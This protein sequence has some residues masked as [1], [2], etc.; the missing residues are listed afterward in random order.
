M[1]APVRVLLSRSLLGFLLV[2]ATVQSAQAWFSLGLDLAALS[3][4]VHKCVVPL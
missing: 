4:R 3:A 1:L 2:E